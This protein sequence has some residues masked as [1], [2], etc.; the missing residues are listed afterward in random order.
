[1]VFGLRSLNAGRY[2][3]LRVEYF[4]QW[5]REFYPGEDMKTFPRT[6]R[7]MC[8]VD[9]VQHMWCKEDIP[10]ELEWT[11]LVL[12]P[13]GTT[14]TLGIGLLETLWKVEEVI[15]DTCL[16]ACL[17]FHD[18]LHSFRS[19]RGTGTSIMDPNITQ[20][21]SSVDYDPIFMVFLDA[22]KA[23][24]TINR[25]HIIQTLEGYGEGPSLCV[26]L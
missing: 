9:I 4:K 15:I 24:D 23:Y 21:L 25:Y 17:Q 1:M 16:R 3:H 6:E 14:D 18:V 26:L 19:R 20:E 8:L 13:K 12:I 2:T 11:I 10:Q 5:V 7:W 22:N